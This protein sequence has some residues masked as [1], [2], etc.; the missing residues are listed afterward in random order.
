MISK[1]INATR[2]LSNP[3][4]TF[5]A[6]YRRGTVGGNRTLQ[7]TSPCT[8]FSALVYLAHILRRLPRPLPATCDCLRYCKYH[9]RLVARGKCHRLSWHHRVAEYQPF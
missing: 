7:C 8:V 5:L 6:T 3:F 1:R 2:S 9:Q 4:F